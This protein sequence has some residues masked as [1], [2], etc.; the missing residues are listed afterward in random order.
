MKQQYESE[1]T[2]GGAVPSG[3][4]IT[5]DD[6]S[7]RV[8]GKLLTPASM[9]HTIRHV[10]RNMVRQALSASGAWLAYWTSDWDRAESEWWWTCC[11]DKEYDVETIQST[12]GRRDIRR[13]LR[14]CSV[15]RLE[16]EEFPDLAHDIYVMSMKA[17]GV[18]KS[19]IRSRAGYREEIAA[20]RAAGEIEFWGAFVGDQLAAFS[21][22]LIADDAV[23][24]GSSKSDPQFHS[25]CPNNALFYTITRHYLRER[26]LR[27]IT[28]GS[29]T[30]SH[31]TSINQML[32]RM[33][34]R[35]I[36]CR[37][38]VVMTPPAKMIHYSG[39]GRWGKC[40]KA[41]KVPG[42]PWDKIQAFH[43]LVEISRT[44]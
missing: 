29:R 5:I 1:P 12:Y 21:I 42:F 39:I 23:S 24:F 37:L 36:Y 32:I 31:P 11:D 28:N 40:V 7:W 2:P 22:C 4:V 14:S 34:F 8:S 16:P 20:M 27:Y 35:Q 30:L 18:S 3:N 13:G 41:L 44:F 10:D 26:G 15:T 25:H 38:N 17:Y 33:G 6:I 19:L 43:T 9:P